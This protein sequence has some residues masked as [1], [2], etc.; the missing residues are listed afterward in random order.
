[1]S[2]NP[3]RAD[4]IATRRESRNRPVSDLAYFADALPGRA[5]LGPPHAIAA[6]DP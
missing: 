6:K 3:G 5:I 1:M 2:V 4:A